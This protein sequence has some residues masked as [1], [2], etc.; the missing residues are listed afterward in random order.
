MARNQP[1]LPN[2]LIIGAAKAGT[3]SLYNYLSVHPEIFMSKRKELS[4]FDPQRRWHLGVE[5]Y[6]SNFDASYPVNG[7]ASPRYTRYPRTTGVPE[8]IQQTLGTP[9]LIYIL[10]DPINRLLAQYTQ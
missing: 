4:F 8:R 7:E 3:T 5:W 1:T 2:F 6:K 10:R 9:K